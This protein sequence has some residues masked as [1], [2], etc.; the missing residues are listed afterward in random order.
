VHN[1]TGV[2]LDGTVVISLGGLGELIEALAPMHMCV[3]TEITSIHTGR[4]YPTGCYDIDADAAIDLVRQRTGLGRGS[5]DRNGIIQ[6][7]MAA[8]LGRAIALDLFADAD[9]IA[10]LSRLDGVT[11]NAPGLDPVA[12]AG[13]VW[14]ARP[15]D[16]FGI[17]SPRFLPHPDGQGE[18]LDPTVA[19]ELFA[20]LG[21]DTMAGFVTAHPDWVTTT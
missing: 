12:L 19:A 8:L 13:Q 21:T 6:D 10:A 15:Y 4:T 18:Q 3:V 2:P 20:A 7:M 17:V 11:V 5:Y 1:L 9:R 14:T 16:L